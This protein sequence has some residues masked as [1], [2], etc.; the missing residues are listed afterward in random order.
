MEWLIII[1]DIQYVSW[2]YFYDE[3][4]NVASGLKYHH[5]N[6]K[7]STKNYIKFEHNARL[8]E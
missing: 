2:E 8:W 7:N 6:S 5:K 3:I 1:I 4:K